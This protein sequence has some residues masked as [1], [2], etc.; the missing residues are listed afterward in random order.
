[1][2]KFPDATTLETSPER[3]FISSLM[4]ASKAMDNAVI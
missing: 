2:L 4:Q 1:M 3:N